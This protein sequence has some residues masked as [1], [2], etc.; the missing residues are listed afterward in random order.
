M[1]APAPPRL[2]DYLQH[3]DQAIWAT[4]HQDLPGLQ[5]QMAALLGEL[6]NPGP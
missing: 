4:I 3:I 2:T 1:S 6:G 5:E